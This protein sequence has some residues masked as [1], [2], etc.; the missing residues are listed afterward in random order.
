MKNLI[1]ILILL[2]V[3]SGCRSSIQNGRFSISLEIADTSVSEIIIGYQT[4]I[5]LTDTVQNIKINPDNRIQ[6]VIDSI[7][8]PLLVFLSKDKEN[9]QIWAWPN[10]DISIYF[11][12]DTV[13]FS[14]KGK[15]YADYYIKSKEYWFK[16]YDEY[17][18]K[19][20]VLNGRPEGSNYFLVQDSITNDRIQ[21]LE[22]Y[23]SKPRS[24]DTRNFVEY[25]KNN[26]LYSDIFYKISGLTSLDDFKFYQ[27]H[28]NIS[29]VS[30]LTF[31]DKFDFNNPDLFI[32]SQY[33]R[34]FEWLDSKYIRENNLDYY[35]DIEEALDFVVSLSQNELCKKYIEVFLLNDIILDSREMR[36]YSVNNWINERIDSLEQKNDGIE[37]Y[38]SILKT[39]YKELER[40]EEVSKYLISILKDPEYAEG[41]KIND[42]SANEN[43]DIFREIMQN[44]P[45]KILYVDFW[46][47]WCAPCMAEMPYSKEL[48]HRYQNKDIVFVYLGFNCTRPSWE[49]TIS[50][51]QLKGEHYLLTDNQSEALS[52]IFKFSGIPRYIIID[53]SGI[54]INGNAPRPSNEDELEKIFLEILK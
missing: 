1:L 13:L 51:L 48:Q 52:D 7:E 41:I 39:K 37:E 22:N 47:P 31:T 6:Y 5:G 3:F 42:L 49:A 32:I 15:K 23:F 19:N 26:L 30:Y 8:D 25:E 36:N 18:S 11:D 50:E 34:C 33:R 38:L 40:D 24:L 53:K 44:Y 14:G 45:G 16:I 29:A 12:N 54:V 21:Y 20:T 2:I 10:S 28:Q 4:D 17:A 43:L 46:A 35:E 9:F 27:E